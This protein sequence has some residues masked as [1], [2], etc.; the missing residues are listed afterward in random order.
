MRILLAD[1]HAIF[2]RGLRD[3]LAEEFPRAE[4]GEADRAQAVL[5]LLHKSRWNLLILDV[6][7]PG[8]SGVDILRDIR[9]VRPE[10]PILVLSMHPE[11][12][13]AERVLRAGAAGYITKVNAPQDIL[14][15]VRRV[16]AGGRYVSTN[17]A[18]KLASRLATGAE[19]A[20]HETL[21]DREYEI[22]VML[23]QGKSV[24]DIATE[25]SLSVPTISTHRARLLRKMDLSTNAEL[26][27]YALHHRLVE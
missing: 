1:D 3:V 15:A 25:L 6:S 23:A 4:F 22:M 18:E 11:E 14:S 13:Y 17:L 20:A 8:R 19:A 7:M 10:L 21:S 26:M 9:Q 5:D 24:K 27:R 12:Q 16:V 2:R